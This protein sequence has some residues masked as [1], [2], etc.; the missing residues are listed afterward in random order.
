MRQLVKEKE[1]SEGKLRLKIDLVS[2][3]ARA[4]GLGKYDNINNYNNNGYIYSN[5]GARYSH[6]RIGKGTGM[7]GNRGSESK[8]S[9]L[10]Y[11]LDQPEYWVK[12][13]G[14]EE[15]C[16]HSNTSVKNSQRNLVKGISTW[17]VH[18]VRYSGPILKWNRELKQM[19]LR[20]RKLMT[21]HKALHPRDRL[22]VWRKEGG[23]GLASIEDSLDTWY[24][25][26]KT[27]KK[28]KARRKTNYSHQ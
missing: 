15:T 3:P 9:K 27:T 23:R 1:N 4:E 16:C 17:A 8:P 14:L 7:H 11:Y 25:D 26:S 10:Q 22:Y 21:M 13:W 12:S 6:Q 2:Y 28:K 19:D 24:N 18:L 20:T 5:W